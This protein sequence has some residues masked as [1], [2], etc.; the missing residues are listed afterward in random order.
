M[1]VDWSFFLLGLIIG[2][3]V[4]A[5]MMNEREARGNPRSYRNA[6]KRRRK[7]NKKYGERK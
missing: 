4:V 6:K 2:A 5:V 1:I 7:S 3:A